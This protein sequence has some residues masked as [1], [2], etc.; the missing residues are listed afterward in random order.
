MHKK[1]TSEEIDFIKQN[2]F[3]MNS[4]QMS[5]ILGRTVAGVNGKIYKIVNI[6]NIEKFG[7]QNRKWKGCG[8]LSGKQFYSM[9]HNAKVRNILFDLT[10]KDV[11]ELF[12][13]QNGKC[14]YTGLDLDFNDGSEVRMHKK[15]KLG[16]ASLDRISRDL[17]YQID[18]VQFLHKHINKMKNDYSEIQFFDWIKLIINPQVGNISNDIIPKAHSKNFSGV[19]NLY[20][21]QWG[22]I[23]TRAK[24][25]HINILITIENAWNLFCSQNGCCIYSGLPLSMP[26]I[27]KKWGGTAS[28]DRIDSLED[29]TLDNIQ[30][31]HKDLN[32]MKWDLS[33]VYFREMCKLVYDYRGL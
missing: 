19:G 11:Y 33:D 25:K 22:N 29:Y 14:N 20:K 23:I 17:P 31:I 4:K 9:K 7:N 28:L 12:E 6:E 3:V 26:K 15:Y 8:T 21:S 30:W 2:Y 1:W 18:N 5:N 27:G 24:Q 16:T 32:D 13:K 10:I